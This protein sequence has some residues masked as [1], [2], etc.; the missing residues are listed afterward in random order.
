MSRSLRFRSDGSFTITQFTDIHWQDGGEA[1]QRSRALMEQVLDA[2]H[3]DLVVFTGDVVASY[4]ARDPVR[5]LREAVTS[6]EKR[7]IPWAVTFGNHDTERGVTRAELMA[8]VLA[9]GH[10]VTERGPEQV[11]GFGNFALPLLDGTGQPRAV[12]YFLD[13]GNLSPSPR[14]QGYDWIRRDQIGWYAQ[15]SAAF[16]RQ[17]G[18]VPL[19]SLAFFH[20]PLPEYEQVWE[21]EVCYGHKYEP[22]CCP[23]VN[24]GLFAA[25]VEMGDVV[26]T[27][28]GHDHINDYWGELYGIRLCYGRATGYN[29][30]GRE[31]FPRGAR[32]IRLQAGR[33]EFDTWLRLE[34]GSVVR[35]QPEH[36]PAA[37]K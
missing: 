12:L 34:D 2:E 3:P 25:M 10:N 37:A 17:N 11:H 14:V 6:V 13:S 33:R 18:G 20:I 30:Y 35:Q 8:A 5:A 16:T 32:I 4:A 1:D 29:T 21:R 22:V 27:F 36:R 26:G 24:T 9:H 15:T 7:G 19:P 28:V 23:R 31:G